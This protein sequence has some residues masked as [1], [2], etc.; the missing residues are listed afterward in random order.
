MTGAALRA[1]IPSPMVTAAGVDWSGIPW[2]IIAIVSTIAILFY[3]CR[4]EGPAAGTET[5]EEGMLAAD[6][7]QEEEAAVGLP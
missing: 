4:S 2:A 1:L 3:L 6:G 7:L 5:L